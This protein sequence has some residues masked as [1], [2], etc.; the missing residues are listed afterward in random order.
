MKMYVEVVF[1][2]MMWDAGEDGRC[3]Y[4]TKLAT[5]DTEDEA[6]EFLKDKHDVPT[7]TRY[8]IERRIV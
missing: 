8:Y 2:C 4:V 7:W 5:F 1:D 6:R 3:P